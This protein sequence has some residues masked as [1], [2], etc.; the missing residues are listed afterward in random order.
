MKIEYIKEIMTSDYDGIDENIKYYYEFNINLKPKGILIYYLNSEYNMQIGKNFK[1]IDSFFENFF[2][3]TF[4]YRKFLFKLIFPVAGL[5]AII[6]NT[7]AFN[8][9]FN[10]SLFN[11]KLPVIAIIA[12]ATSI[13]DILNVTLEVLNNN[14][15]ILIR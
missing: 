11:K 10:S 9:K 7:K 15:A 5:S 6:N 8:L 12:A 14:K 4:S 1:G 13:M 3:R 2:K